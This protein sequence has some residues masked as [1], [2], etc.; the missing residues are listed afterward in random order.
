MVYEPP[1]ATEKG[2]TIDALVDSILSADD[3]PSL[4]PV[5]AKRFQQ[6]M[7]DTRMIAA[8]NEAV[9]LFV[10]LIVFSS[11]YY[12]S[13]NSMINNILASTTNLCY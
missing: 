2:I 4:L 5:S 12:L 1:C 11:P 10:V 8:T 7:D 13:K 3:Q 6:N 9:I